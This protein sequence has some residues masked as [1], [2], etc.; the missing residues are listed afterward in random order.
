MRHHTEN[1]I[2]EF[3]T[4]ER[5]HIYWRG[6]AHMPSRNLS[7]KKA[8]MVCVPRGFGV[9]YKT[10]LEGFGLSDPLSAS[11]WA[12]WCCQSKL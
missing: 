8:V 2:I 3:G 7:P 5:F 4:L 9:G 1:K 6:S 10:S 11:L 12:A